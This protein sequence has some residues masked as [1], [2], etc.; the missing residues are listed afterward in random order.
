MVKL[1]LMPAWNGHIDCAQGIVSGWAADLARPDHWV[2]V[3]LFADSQPAGVVLADQFRQDLLDA[4]VG[5]GRHAFNHCLPLG[6]GESF[7]SIG[8]RIQGTEFRL[9]CG[10]GDS[11]LADTRVFLDFVACD[12]VNNCN[13]RCPFCFVDYSQIKKTEL[14]SETTFD[15]MQALLP[16]VPDGGF[17]LS[18]LHEPTLHPRFGEFIERIPAACRKKIRFTTNLAM[19]LREELLHTWAKSGIHHVSISLDTLRPELFPILRKGGRLKIFLQ[20]LEKLTEIFGATADAPGIRYITMAFRSNVDEL[21]G[22]VRLTHERYHAEL[23]EIRCCTYDA[24]HVS[25][26]FRKAQYLN[27][28]E[29]TRMLESLREV[30]YPYVVSPP[31]S[32]KIEPSANFTNLQ[33]AQLV[34]HSM[35]PVPLRLRARPDGTLMIDGHENSWRINVNQEPYPAASLRALTQRVLQDR[36]ARAENLTH[37]PGRCFWTKWATYRPYRKLRSV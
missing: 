21:A 4:G 3:E 16:A 26:E 32:D 28:Q 30:P 8:A 29:W 10:T 11:I 7:Q 12:I 9:H 35:L 22:L 31:P 36:S 27:P 23:H 13:L 34:D 5:D 20:N 1:L 18:C 6:N 19:P 25:D 37:A 2:K 14:M 24:E 33:C 15:R 17:W